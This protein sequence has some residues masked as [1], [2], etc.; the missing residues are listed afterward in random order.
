IERDILVEV[1]DA[2]DGGLGHPDLA[3][4]VALGDVPPFAADEECQSL[5]ELY[6][7]RLIIQPMNLM[8]FNQAADRRGVFASSCPRALSSGSSPVMGALQQQGNLGKR[9]Q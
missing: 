4:E 7:T 1:L 9:N 2:H 3:R 5:P 8:G 6:H